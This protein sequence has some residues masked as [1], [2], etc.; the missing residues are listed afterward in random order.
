MSKYE[1][2]TEE[3]GIPALFKDGELVRNIVSVRIDANNEEAVMHIKQYVPD[4]DFV[5]EGRIVTDKYLT[6][7][8]KIADKCKEYLEKYSGRRGLF[9]PDTAKELEEKEQIREEL[10]HYLYDAGYKWEELC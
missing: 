10:S 1:L 2:K 4:L 3:N 8:I 9:L 5:A 6:S 7:L